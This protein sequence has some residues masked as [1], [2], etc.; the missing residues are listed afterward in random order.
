MNEEI[1]TQQSLSLFHFQPH[2][3]SI[4][5]FFFVVPLLNVLTEVFTH[6]PG[7]L[8]RYHNFTW[9]QLGLT[10]RFLN[11]FIQIQEAAPQTRFYKQNPF[12]DIIYKFTQTQLF[13]VI[14]LLDSQLPFFPGSMTLLYIH[15]IVTLQLHFLHTKFQMTEEFVLRKR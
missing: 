13:F 15:K 8:P 2:L 11:N 12:Q 14:S 5:F 7:V 10:V 4:S 3:R 9:K 6:R 1:L